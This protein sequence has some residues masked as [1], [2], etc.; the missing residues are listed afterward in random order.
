MNKSVELLSSLSHPWTWPVDLA[1]YDRSPDLG[2]AERAELKRVMRRKPFHVYPSTKERLHRLLEPIQDV[3]TVT[4]LN[5]QICSETM[6]VLVVEMYRRG[7]T[8]WAWSEQEWVDIIGPSYSAFARRYGRRYGVGQHPARRELPV[9]AYLLCSLAEIDPLLRPFAIVPIARK[10]F[11][12]AAIEAHV[13]LLTAALSAW[14]YQEKNHHDFIACLCYL[15]LRNRSPQLEDLH[16]EF[17]E[18]VK[19]TCTFPCVQSYLFQ[20]SRALA[21]HGMISRPLPDPKRA[22]RA[23]TSETDGKISESWLMWCR[24]W[25]ESSTVQ[26][27]EHTYY[28][29]LKVGRW[30]NVNHPEVSSP[31]DFTYEIATEFVAAVMDMKVGEWISAGRRVLSTYS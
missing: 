4:H 17:L 15:L 13:K 22:A 21:A 28:L 12:E 18:T 1:H 7:K 24:R 20:V 16:L 27:K 11:G 9:L 30:L 19:A 25:R 10:V 23:A 2:E 26:E 29:L 6:R 14:G 5:A 3:F 31:A 8:F